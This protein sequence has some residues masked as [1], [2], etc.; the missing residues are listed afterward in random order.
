MGFKVFGSEVLT[1]ADVNNLLMRQ[2]NIVCTSTTRPAA[3]T[4]GMEIYETDTKFKLRYDASTS[5]WWRWPQTI[6][7]ALEGTNLTGIT[8][9]SYIAGSPTC[10]ILIAG[11]PS[12]SGLV[13]V[14]TH[15][16]GQA[17]EKATWVAYE[18][19]LTNSSGAVVH[20][21]SDDEAVLIQGVNNVKASYASLL[22]GLTVGQVYYL[23]TMH[24][25]DAATT[26]T[27]FHR[28]I[29]FIPTAN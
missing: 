14:G 2:T 8:S 27:V 18:A 24:K 28:R 1:S 9:T 29:T 15:I 21:A 20:A 17:T 7:E 13:V 22:T 10:S 4:D 19:R 26:G 6:T 3:P 5:A 25:V 16:E 23:R 12:G 11:P